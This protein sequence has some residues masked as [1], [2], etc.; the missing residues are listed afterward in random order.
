MQ[1]QGTA[2]VTLCANGLFCSVE[3]VISSDPRDNLLVGCEN[4]RRLKFI[5]ANFPHQTVLAIS[6]FASLNLLSPVPMQTPDGHMHINMDKDV[7]PIKR[8]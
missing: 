3:A 4:L 1:V 8:W 2:S 7:T 6:S 5:P